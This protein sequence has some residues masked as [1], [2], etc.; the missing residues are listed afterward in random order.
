MTIT[1]DNTNEVLTEQLLQQIFIDAD[2]A[3]FI[4][5]VEQTVSQDVLR[6]VI[7]LD[8]ASRHGLIAMLPPRVSSVAD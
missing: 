5:I 8:A 6:I 3:R 7:R 1:D 4:A 2:A